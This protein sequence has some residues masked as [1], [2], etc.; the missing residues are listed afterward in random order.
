MKMKDLDIL[1]ENAMS[2]KGR[3]LFD[4]ENLISMVRNLLE[5]KSPSQMDLDLGAAKD[6]AQLSGISGDKSGEKLLDISAISRQLV[7]GT[8]S[9]ENLQGIDKAFETLRKTNP[10]INELHNA[11]A[12]TFPQAMIDALNY[13]FSPPSEILDNPC[14]GLGAMMSRH[15]ILD[16]YLSIFKQYNAQSA[17]FVNESFISSLLGGKTLTI[18]G[19]HSSIADIQ[20]GNSGVSLKTS[21]YDGKLSGSFSSLL[22][23]LG[24]KYKTLKGSKAHRSD[25]NTPVHSDGLYYLLFNKQKASHIITAFRV[26]REEII[27]QL[28]H[29]TSRQGNRVTK[30]EDGYYIFSEIPDKA[31]VKDI[32]GVL[33][34]DFK[35]VPSES[36][37][38]SNVATAS[39][40]IDLVL[41][42]VTTA[43]DENV[44]RIIE[45]I[46]ALTDFYS[47]LSNAIIEFAT[48]PDYE[49]LAKIKGDLDLAAQMQPEKLISN[50]C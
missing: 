33:N 39:E 35:S 31:E 4:A 37:G 19:G 10:Y 41:P 12:E 45:T 25:N 44:A 17:G 8:E 24:I 11:S 18:K 28:E 40:D 5:K 27:R 21:N 49:N 43:D 36:K 20:I 30:D 32:T 2:A 42:E 34:I 46:S 50:Q 16:A 29:Q 9:S 14:T 22:R 3:Q 47:I 1:I 26:D 7:R 48:N 6:P 38:I 23:T 13:Y 15:M